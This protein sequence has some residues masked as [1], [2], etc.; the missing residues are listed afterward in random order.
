MIRT[1]IRN[2]EDFRAVVQN[3]DAIVSLTANDRPTC[4]C[5]ETAP[6]DAWLRRER[7]A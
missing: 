2:V 6:A 4:A 1:D 3:A 5:G 7:V